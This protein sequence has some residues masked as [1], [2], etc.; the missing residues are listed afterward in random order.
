MGSI[1]I[2]ALKGRRTVA[3]DEARW[4]RRVLHLR[5]GAYAGRFTV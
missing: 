2:A 5:L 3:G 1:S 4:V